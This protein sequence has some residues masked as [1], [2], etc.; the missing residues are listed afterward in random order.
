M[1][2]NSEFPF[3]HFIFNHLIFFYLSN[4][5]SIDETFSEVIIYKA[6]YMR[7]KGSILK[8]NNQLFMNDN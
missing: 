3:I 4:H 5:S 2:Q 6:R 8:M 7:S 1:T